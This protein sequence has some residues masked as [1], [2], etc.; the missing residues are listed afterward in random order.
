MIARAG[1]HD[2]DF[3]VAALRARFERVETWIFDQIGRA[4]V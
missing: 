4:H 3:D 2:E 1:G